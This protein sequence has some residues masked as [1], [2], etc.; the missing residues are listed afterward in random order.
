[1]AVNAMTTTVKESPMKR[2]PNATPGPLDDRP[3]PRRAGRRLTTLILLAAALWTGAA[4][5][6]VDLTEFSA[7]EVIRADEVNA[8][9]RSLADLAEANE[10]RLD[11][12]AEAETAGTLRVGPH[13]VVPFAT[14][15]TSSTA[16]GQPY[17]FMRGVR[18]KHGL[19]LLGS[20]IGSGGRFCFGTGL[21]L[22]D[23][24]TIVAFAA[25]LA[26]P[27]ASGTT[28]L[29]EAYLEVRSWTDTGADTVAEVAALGGDYTQTATI[30]G[31]LP[32]TVDTA[33][34]EYRVVTCLEGD[35]GFLG[36]RIEH[37]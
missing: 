11:A 27:D 4:W 20:A 18:G 13:D 10:A 9:F 30:G 21:D 5:A 37:E 12:A 34:N 15:I 23:G 17:E 19:E 8:N 3:F 36:A 28:D 7:G 24:A 14:Y 32:V 22:P 29:A 2:A 33:A 6:Q 26:D 35:G 25:I 1:M 31:D 16:N